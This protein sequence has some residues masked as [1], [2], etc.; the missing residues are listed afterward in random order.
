M[1]LL[2]VDPAHYDVR[3]AINPHMRGADGSLKKVDRARAREEW[4]ALRR[5]FERLGAT[6][7]VIEGS[8]DHPDMVFAA[9]HGLPF[10][11]EVILARMAHP[12]R[13]G[14]VALFRSWYE[15]N[16]YRIPE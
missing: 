3:Y 10:G 15:G 1:K 4:E 2:M 14:E 9:N 5:T 7:E 13:E 16:G 6:V 11:R 8:P 12:D